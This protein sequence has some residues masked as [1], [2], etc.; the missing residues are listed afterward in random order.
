VFGKVVDRKCELYDEVNCRFMDA[1]QVRQELDD[2]VGG[3]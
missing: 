3:N 1:G 2:N